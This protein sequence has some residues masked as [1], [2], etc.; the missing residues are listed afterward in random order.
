[1]SKLINCGLQE[2]LERYI[3]ENRELKNI[4]LKLEKELEEIKNGGSEKN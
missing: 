1:M 4:I 2:L 3:T